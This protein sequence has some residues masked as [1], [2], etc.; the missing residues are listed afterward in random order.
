[1]RETSMDYRKKDDM[2]RAA[3]KACG[4]IA[5]EK[6][7][8]VSK[9]DMNHPYKRLYKC[10]GKVTKDYSEGGKVSKMGCKKKK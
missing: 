10:G 6:E 2:Y 4:S 5:E 7:P 9:G 1:M 8:P 3:K